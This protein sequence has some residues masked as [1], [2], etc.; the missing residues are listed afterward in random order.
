MIVWEI[1]PNFIRL[2]FI[3]KWEHGGTEH[4]PLIAFSAVE[5]IEKAMKHNAKPISED[6]LTSKREANS[7][8]FSLLFESQEKL[9]KFLKTLNPLY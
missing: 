1:H 8:S 4:L 6:I 7:V 3:G 2:D 5:L 9:E